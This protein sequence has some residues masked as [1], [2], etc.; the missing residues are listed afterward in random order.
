MLKK[1]GSFEEIKE[2]I[3]KPVY[4]KRDDDDRWFLVYGCNSDKMKEDYITLLDSDGFVHDIKEDHFQSW[5][6][7]YLTEA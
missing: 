1:I 4:G 7:K 2:M 3:G 6:L 5:K